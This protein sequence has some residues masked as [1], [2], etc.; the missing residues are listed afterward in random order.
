LELLARSAR[1]ATCESAELLA[2][3]FRKKA[4]P[5]GFGAAKSTGSRAMIAPDASPA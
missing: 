3:S 1:L 4:R 5:Y 2:S